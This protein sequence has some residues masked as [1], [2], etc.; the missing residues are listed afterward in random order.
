[1][2]DRVDPIKPFRSKVKKI[3]LHNL[4]VFLFYRGSVNQG[5]DHEILLG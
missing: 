3:A 1:M 5:P 2:N 4:D